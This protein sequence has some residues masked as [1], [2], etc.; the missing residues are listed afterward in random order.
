MREVNIKWFLPQLIS[1]TVN[2]AELTA[3]E[4]GRAPNETGSNQ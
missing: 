2:D 3:A 4:L 1:L